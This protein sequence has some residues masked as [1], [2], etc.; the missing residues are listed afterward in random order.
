MKKRIHIFIVLGIAI[1]AFILGS[2]FDQQISSKLYIPNF[3]LGHIVSG[4][5]LFVTFGLGA[6]YAGALLAFGLKNE[7]KNIKFILTFISILILLIVIYFS[8]NEVFSVNALNKKGIGY[9]LLGVGIFLIINIPFYILGYIFGK[10]LED[11]KL[12]I[13]ILTIIIAFGVCLLSGAVGLKDIFHR[14]RYRTVV[15]GI[16]GIDFHNWWEPFKN[17]KNFI[18]DTITK[19][20]FKSF[21][22]GHATTSMSSIIGFSYLFII[23]PKLKNK[24]I[25]L[26]YIGVLYSIVVSLTRIIAGAH[27][28]SDVSFGSIISILCFII[29]NEIIIRKKLIEDIE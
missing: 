13:L 20:E 23:F 5:G 2:I 15:L 24:Q 27:F 16:E 1:I 12:W 9:K 21:P 14:P 11:D 19:E 25:I 26:F 28:L 18:T 22:S 3:T 6:I 17:Y 8:G 7:K 10:K 4:F 29:G